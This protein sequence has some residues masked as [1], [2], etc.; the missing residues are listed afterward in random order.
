MTVSRLTPALQADTPAAAAAALRARG[1]RVS[2]ARREL[3]EALYAAERPLTAEEIADGG[4]LGSAYRNLEALEDVGLVRHVHLGHG[5]GLYTR[6]ARAQFVVLPGVRALHPVAPPSRR[7]PRRGARRHRLARAFSHFPI[8][9]LPRLRGEASDDRPRPRGTHPGGWRRA[10]GLAAAVLG[11]HVVG[12]RPA[13][14]LVAPQPLQPRDGG[15]FGVG[16]GLTA[17]TLGLRHAFDAD[18]IAAI[19][20]TTRK[21]MGEG[22]RPLERRLLLLARPLDVVFALGAALRDRGARPERR[23]RGRRLGAARGHRA[24]RPGVSGTFLYSSGSLNL[25]VL[26]GIVR[27]LPRMRDGALRRGRARGRSSTTAA[28]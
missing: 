2:S 16:L 17:Y 22:Q 24:D 20:N 12:L 7:P 27:R 19:D 1:L 11:L 21:L 14:R 13:A 6:P 25:V 18:H 28:S 23:G 26:I 9:G 5:A 10:G 15:V 8:A 4:D 3:L